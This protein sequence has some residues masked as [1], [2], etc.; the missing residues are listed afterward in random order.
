MTEEKSRAVT[1]NP[2]NQNQYGTFQGV[3]NYYPP[4]AQTPPQPAVGFPQPLP[5][6]ASTWNPLSNAHGYQTITGIS[7]FFLGFFE[8]EFGL[9]LGDI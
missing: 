3:A 7:I 8:L 5:P 1:G 6:P 9:L 2:Q 4:L